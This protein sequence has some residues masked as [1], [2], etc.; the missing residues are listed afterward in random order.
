MKTKR[1]N[2]DKS[3][4]GVDIECVCQYDADLSRNYF[5]ENFEI[6]QHNGYRTQSVLYFI[7]NGNIEGHEAVKMTVKGTRETKEKFIVDLGYQDADEVKTWDDETLDAE[8]LGNVEDINLI[9]YALDKMEDV[10]GLEFVPSKNLI[11]LATCGYS[12]GD[13]S[14]VLYCPE[15]LEKAWGEMPTQESIQKMVNHYCWDAPIYARFEIDGKEYRYDDMPTSDEYEWDRDAFIAYVSKE[16]GIDVE[17][18]E[19]FVPEYPEYV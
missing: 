12:Q 9:N 18:L 5:E 3:S 11:T 17:K 4:T 6:L 7:E 10:P 14:T 8:I 2:Y 13:Y 16:S 19:S 15:D 1:N